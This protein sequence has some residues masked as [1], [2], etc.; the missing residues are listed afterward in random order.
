[1]SHEELAMK[2]SIGRRNHLLGLAAALLGTAC[3]STRLKPSTDHPANARAET[4]PPLERDDILASGPATKAAPPPQAHDQAAPMAGTYTCPMHPQ[5]V[6][7]APGQC[8]ICGMNL[9]KKESAS[10]EG[11]AHE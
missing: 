2:Q 9:V 3:V 1:L 11:A 4:G 10:P 6:R 8:P 5:V 7:N